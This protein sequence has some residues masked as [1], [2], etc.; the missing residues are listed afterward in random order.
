[1]HSISAGTEKSDYIR[2]HH[3]ADS[4]T[5]G[6]SGWFL[7]WLRAHWRERI[8][9]AARI[10]HTIGS[11]DRVPAWRDSTRAHHH[12]NRRDRSFGHAIP[13]RVRN[14]CFDLQERL[15]G[16]RSYCTAYRNRPLSPAHP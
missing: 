11:S 9:I 8:R 7:V 16:T 2:S 6:D 10:A 15:F 13:D 4:A 5:A 14:L 3:N 12:Y 1:S